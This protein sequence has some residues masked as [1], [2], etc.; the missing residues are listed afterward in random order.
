M[1]D[2]GLTLRMQLLLSVVR[3]ALFWMVVLTMS[4]SITFATT[5]NPAVRDVVEYEPLQDSHLIVRGTVTAVGQ[6][7]ISVAEWFSTRPSTRDTDV[8]MQM[9]T[10]EVAV[11]EVLK[12]QLNDSRV[13]FMV[14]DAWPFSTGQ[15]VVICAKLVR[16][17]TERAFFTSAYTGMYARSENAW[18]RCAPSNLD[19]T[20]VLTIDDIKSRIQ[21]VNLLSMTE[22]S[23]VIVRGTITS[24]SESSYEVV[25]GRSGKLTRYQFHVSEA[26]KGRINDDEIE[27][28]VPRVDATYVPKW[29]RTVPRGLEAGQEWILFLK[30]G[31]LGLYLFSGPNSALMVRGSELIYDMAVTYPQSVERATKIIRFETSD[32][33][34]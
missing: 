1:K 34:R 26:L 3:C 17:K 9:E 14:A 32:D 15:Q 23:E 2:S 4:T 6:E 7:A 8:T 24:V 21:Q 13:K 30:R 29:Y 22:A 11:A 25:G 31:E 10:L 18:T 12:G 20:Q 16:G 19:A 27:F 28:I 33:Q 5:K